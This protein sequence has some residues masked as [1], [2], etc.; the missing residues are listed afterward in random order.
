MSVVLLLTVILELQLMV[1]TIS[2]LAVT[3]DSKVES[4]LTY[5]VLVM[6]LL[7]PTMS[8]ISNLFVIKLSVFI[9]VV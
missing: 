1:S 7:C 8:R 6:V 3:V 5:N 9:F 4:P 2:L